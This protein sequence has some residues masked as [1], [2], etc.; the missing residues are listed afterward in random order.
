MSE[1]TDIDP[2]GHARMLDVSAKEATLRWAVAEGRVRI[3][4]ALADKIEANAIVKGNLLEMARVAGILAAKRTDELIP[5]CHSLPLDYVEVDA[6]LERPWVRLRA[7]A[8][9]TAKAGVEM[10]AF[11]AVSVAALT[12]ID[13]G[14]SVD[15]AMVIEEIRLIE[16][17]GGRHGHYIVH[18]REQ[19]P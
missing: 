2:S 1:P 6:W 15:P 8:T 12:V 7:K 5:L 13:M 14:K 4:T 9:V 11:T 19:T 10:E 18:R 3:S 16:K 17:A